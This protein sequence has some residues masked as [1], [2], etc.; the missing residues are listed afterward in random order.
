MGSGEQTQPCQKCGAP[1]QKGLVGMVTKMCISCARTSYPAEWATSTQEQEAT[2]GPDT[3]GPGQAPQS[4]AEKATG[5]D[6]GEEAMVESTDSRKVCDNLR[7][8]GVGH[9]NGFCSGA[10]AQQRPKAL[11]GKN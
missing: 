7:G 2:A 6:M 10:S 11:L 3:D 1:R 8:F 5:D 4:E 9:A